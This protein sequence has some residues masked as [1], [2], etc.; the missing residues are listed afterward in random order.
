MQ[1]I[2]K[3]ATVLGSMLF[4]LIVFNPTEAHAGA[5]I[6]SG[7]VALGVNDQGHLNFTDGVTRTSN[8]GPVGVAYTFPDG[9]LRDATAP[10]CLCEGWGAAATSGVTPHTGYANISSGGISNLTV[11][12]FTSTA[13]TA[14]STVHLTSLPGFTIM[15]EYFPS[16]GAPTAL[17]QD[18]VT[19]TNNT[20]GLLTDVRYTRAM[21]W[22]VPPTEFDE[23]VTIGGLPATDVLHT[24]ANGFAVP[25]P[26][27][28]FAASDSGYTGCGVTTNFTDC[29]PT[30]HGAVW[31]FGFGSLADGESRTFNIYYG[32][33]GTEAAAFA[34]LGEVG[35]EIYSLGQ[36]NDGRVIGFGDPD[37]ELGPAT[38]IFAFGGVGGVALPDPTPSV[39]GGT[40]IPE[41]STLIMLGMGAGAAFLKKRKSAK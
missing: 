29:G 39:P 40:E 14:T 32:A 17:F 30:D 5:V 20:G 2:S 23:F 10:G 11:D 34:A 25:N 38:Y 41:P 27:R 12:S 13:T 28:N 19:I 37:K 1:K 24:S 18:R 16:A 9:T 8:A 35:A 22:D 26:Y 4:A 15:Q 36:H 21:D 7:P 3:I 33:A 31:D 6:Q